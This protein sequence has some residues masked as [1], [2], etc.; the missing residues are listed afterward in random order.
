MVV[1]VGWSEHIEEKAAHSSEDQDDA[2]QNNPPDSLVVGS[3]L[4][5]EEAAAVIPHP[6]AELDN[7]HLLKFLRVSRS[8]SSSHDENLGSEE[9][10]GQRTAIW[11]PNIKLLV[12]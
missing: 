9:M 4:E 10:T 8:P 1:H 2:G 6:P 12:R 5:R 11:L 3:F 7:F